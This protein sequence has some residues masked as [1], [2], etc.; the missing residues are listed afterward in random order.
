MRTESAFYDEAIQTRKEFAKV[1]ATYNVRDHLE[2]RTEIDTLL[3]MYDQAIE[4]ARKWDEMIGDCN[5]V[6]ELEEDPLEGIEF[7]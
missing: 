2:L 3:I 6:V 7:D 5:P 4:K 1:A